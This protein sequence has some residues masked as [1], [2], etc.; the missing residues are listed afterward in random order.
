MYLQ[1][2][3]HVTATHMNNTTVQS[4]AV[5]GR[6]AVCLTKAAA[7]ATSTVRHKCCHP[8]RVARAV[9]PNPWSDFRPAALNLETTM[10]DRQGVQRL[11]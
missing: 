3:A 6:R 1:R 5:N 10:D 7:H 4:R 8:Y 11:T 2:L 9:V